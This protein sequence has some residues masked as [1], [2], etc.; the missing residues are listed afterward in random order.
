MIKV[1]FIE[2]VYRF[3]T[4]ALKKNVI[5]STNIAYTES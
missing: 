2:V 1:D 3:I 5:W 4:L